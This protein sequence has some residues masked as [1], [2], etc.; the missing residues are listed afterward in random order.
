MESAEQG[1]RLLGAG[2]GPAGAPRGQC[3]MQS[4]I[5]ALGIIFPGVKVKNLEAHQDLMW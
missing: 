4:P 3:V 1:C 2:E 5:G